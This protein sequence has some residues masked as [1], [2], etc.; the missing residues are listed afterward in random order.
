MNL[1]EED[2]Q[3]ID[4]I[5]HDR[6]VNRTDAIRGALATETLLRAMIAQGAE[7]TIRERVIPFLPFFHREKRLILR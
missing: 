1:F 3:M 2:I 5:A 4:G 6:G 7:L